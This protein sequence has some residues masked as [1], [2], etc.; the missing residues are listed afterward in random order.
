MYVR[1]PG[2][3]KIVRNISG[4]G[5][6]WEMFY[7]RDAAGYKTMLDGVRLKTLVW[8]ER[9]LL[10][11]FNIEQGKGLPR[12]AHPH[13]QT[14]YLISGRMRFTIGTETFE[15]DPGD[16]WSISGDVEHAAEALEDSK[17]VEVFSP[18]R[19]EYLP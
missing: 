8:G 4:K 9:T 10:C 13:E 7:K 16:S 18:V 1:S 17:G 15:V 2:E 14:G 19:E 12:H 5:K 6:E 11:E 3:E